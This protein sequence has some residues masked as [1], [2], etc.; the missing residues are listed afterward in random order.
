MDEE[1]EQKGQQFINSNF[2]L[3]LLYV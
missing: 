1:I 3:K 2:L